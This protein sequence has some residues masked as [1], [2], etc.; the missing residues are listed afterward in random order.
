GVVVVDSFQS[1]DAARALLGEIRR[2]TPKPVRFVVNTHYHFDHTGG[3]QVFRDAGAM[4]VAHRN[5]RGW[6]RAENPHL[7]GA[8]IT[9][10]LKAM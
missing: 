7:F 1:K 9:P 4:I 8:R 10:E 2:I 6:V 5:V 3:D